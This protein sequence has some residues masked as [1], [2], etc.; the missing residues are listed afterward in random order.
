MGTTHIM[1]CPT[2]I[3]IT[4]MLQ[5]NHI[6]FLD[7]DCT[8]MLD[9]IFSKEEINLIKSNLPNFNPYINDNYIIIEASLH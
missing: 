8:H 1:C 5:Y 2:R 7:L 4:Y 3:G 9:S 6:Y